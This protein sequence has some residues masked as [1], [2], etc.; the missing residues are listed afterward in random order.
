MTDKIITFKE[1]TMNTES[2]PFVW[3][4]DEVDN[5]QGYKTTGEEVLKDQLRVAN[6]HV[7]DLQEAIKYKEECL[8]ILKAEKNLLLSLVRERMR[9][10]G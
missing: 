7:M 6:G 4:P 8:T 1:V 5:R 2:S 9:F 3:G 10:N